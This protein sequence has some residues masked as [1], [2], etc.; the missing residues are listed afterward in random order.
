M[1]SLMPGFCLILLLLAALIGLAMAQ[2]APQFDGQLPGPPK[3]EAQAKPEAVAP[4]PAEERQA[5][6]QAAINAALKRYDCQIAVGMLV[7]P[8]GN[9]QIIQVV[10]NQE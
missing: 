7:T 4:M 9:Q 2:E 1:K 3:P 10:A 6:C 8:H 5:A